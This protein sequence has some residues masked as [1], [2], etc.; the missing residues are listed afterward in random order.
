MKKKLYYTIEKEIDD[1]GG[2]ETLTGNKTI[3][4]YDIVNN[5]PEHFAE[6]FCGNEENS[7]EKINEYL[8]DNGYGDDEYTLILL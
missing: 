2:D 7:K 8:E 5:E 1:N 6:I 3:T 4:V